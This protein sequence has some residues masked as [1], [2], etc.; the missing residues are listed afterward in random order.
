MHASNTNRSFTTGL[1]LR[2]KAQRVPSGKARSKNKSDGPYFF[3]QGT[4]CAYTASVVQVTRLSC[5]LHEATFVLDTHDAVKSRFGNDFKHAG[6]IDFRFITLC[7]ELVRLR[8][9]ALGIRH[10][11]FYSQIFVV[12]LQAN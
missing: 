1:P 5:H 2:L 12:L 10:E 3:K 8:A 6:K 4:C 11:F 7:I 9:N